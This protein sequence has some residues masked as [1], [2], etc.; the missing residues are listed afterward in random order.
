MDA[1]GAHHVK[2]NMSDINTKTMYSLICGRL[3]N[4][5]WKNNI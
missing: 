4:S 1:H 2:E 5:R 3:E